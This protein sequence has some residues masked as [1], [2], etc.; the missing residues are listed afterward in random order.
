MQKI[1]AEKKRNVAVIEAEN[2]RKLA[3][4]RAEV[5]ATTILKEAESYLK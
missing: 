2:I 1:H 4:I 3:K 5:K